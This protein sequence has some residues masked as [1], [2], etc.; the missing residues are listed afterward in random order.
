[1]ADIYYMY[2]Q[3][4]QDQHVYISNTNLSGYTKWDGSW[5]VSSGR[6][7]HIE[8]TDDKFVLPSSAYKLFYDASNSDWSDF[9]S[10]KWDASQCTNIDQ[11]FYTC[12]YLTSIDL[13]GIDFSN[14]TSAEMAISGCRRL[15][16][17][18]MKDAKVDN[19]VSAYRMFDNCQAVTS[20]DVSGWNV[21]KLENMGWM[22]RQN[23]T[24]KIDLSSWNAT[25]ITNLA[26]TFSECPNLQTVD[27]SGLRT[28]KVTSM[29]NMFYR[30]TSLTSI[31]LS[32]VT[33]DSCTDLS[34]MFNECTSLKELDL[35]TFNVIDT[36]VT[37]VAYIFYDCSS[38]ESIY[39]L[40]NTDWSIK[41]PSIHGYRM[42]ENTPLARDGL[43]GIQCANNN[44]HSMG[45]HYF[46]EASP[47]WYKYSIYLKD[48]EGW[49]EQNI[50]LKDNTWELKNVE[51]KTY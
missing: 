10:D 16:S 17:I 9:K 25:N 5:S 37:T 45:S 29:S 18:N 8:L 51:F 40:P 49:N 7:V 19:L 21:Q 4:N 31:D 36:P 15:T 20:I 27:I 3:E 34:N 33:L 48:S 28:T 14:V 1:M 11:M 23:A 32:K 41:S 2:S 12:N 24:S 6:Y 46:K 30:C 39:A 38:L 47:I 35:R 50:Y 44:I 26:Y 22:F 42:F 43:V 13:S